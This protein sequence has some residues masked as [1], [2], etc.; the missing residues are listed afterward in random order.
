MILIKRIRFQPLSTPSLLLNL[1]HLLLKL[2]HP[3]PHR[4]IQPKF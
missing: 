2:I 3:Q 1:F 4:N